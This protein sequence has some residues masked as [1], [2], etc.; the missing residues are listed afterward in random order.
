[1]SDTDAPT[2]NVTHLTPGQVAG[3]AEGLE[4]AGRI[5]S[6]RIPTPAGPA[7]TKPWSFTVNFEGGPQPTD[8]GTGTE[9]DGSHYWVIYDGPHEIDDAVLVGMADED[10]T[11]VL[12]ALV[13]EHNRA[14]TVLWEGETTESVVPLGPNRSCLPSDLRILP[15]SPGTHVVVTWE[16]DRA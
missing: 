16:T 14:I 11:P 2:V 5:D 13:A 15:V 8:Y 6:V 3:A 4:M 7:E 10:P 1:M 12:A 9:W